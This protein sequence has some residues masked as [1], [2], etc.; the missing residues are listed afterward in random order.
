M[1]SASGTASS[2]CYLPGCLSP[3]LSRLGLPPQTN[4]GQGLKQQK[5][6][7]SQLWRLEVMIEVLAGE[8]PPEASLQGLQRAA[9]SLCPLVA[10]CMRACCLPLVQTLV[11][12][13]QGSILMTS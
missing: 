12:S 7:S 6:I 2:A 3:C 9:F 13:D 8:V 10:F 4:T 11:L 1:G 5:L